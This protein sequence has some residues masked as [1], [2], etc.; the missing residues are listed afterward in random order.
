MYILD[1]IFLYCNLTRLHSEGK[2][3]HCT[4]CMYDS[5]YMYMYMLIKKQ[6]NLLKIHY[7]GLI[8]RFKKPLFFRARLG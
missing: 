1:L 3:I 4:L 2:Y 5:W 8:K 6:D 7:P